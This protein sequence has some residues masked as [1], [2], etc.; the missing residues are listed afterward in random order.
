MEGLHTIDYFLEET[1]TVLREEVDIG[2]ALSDAYSQAHPLSD[3]VRFNFKLIKQTNR[4]RTNRTHKQPPVKV[5]VT[6][7]RYK[8]ELWRVVIT[9]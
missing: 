7:E 8:S 3:V 4:T 2:R 9:S 1:F 6:T 5:V